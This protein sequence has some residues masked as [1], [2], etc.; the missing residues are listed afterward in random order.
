MKRADE[1][2]WL[3]KQAHEAGSRSRLMKQADEAGT[4]R[5]VEAAKLVSTSR[6]KKG[7]KK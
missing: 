4:H 1:A 5:D 2:G 3:T 7:R 6:M